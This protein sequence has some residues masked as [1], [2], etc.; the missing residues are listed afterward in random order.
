MRKNTKEDIWKFIDKNYEKFCWVWIGGTFSGRYGRFFY[1]GKPFLAHRFI[2][3][4]FNDDMSDE[5]MVMHKCNNK[6]CCNPNHLTQGS[7][8]DNQNHAS[9]SGVKKIGKIGIRGI[10]FIK[11]R[12]YWS[13]GAYKNGKRFNLYTGPHYEKAI[14]ARKKWEVCNGVTFNG[15]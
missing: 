11:K 5:L 9:L 15:F 1:D 10:Y 13:A 12:N 3:S 6:L 4:M 8:S 14:E 2:Y 7:N